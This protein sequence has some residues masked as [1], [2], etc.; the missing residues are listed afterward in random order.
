MKYLE[1]AKIKV[2]SVLNKDT[3]SYGKQHLTDGSLET[4]WNSDQGPNQFILIQFS[5]PVDTI[6]SKISFMFQGGFV[7]RSVQIHGWSQSV[8]DAKLIDTVYPEDI[9]S[10]QSFEVKK[11]GWDGSPLAGIKIL[12]CESSDFY[13]RITLYHLGLE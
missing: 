5:S 4:C 12:F 9:N 2:S 6:P 10:M 1:N 7:G 3:K 13:G 11:D 8:S